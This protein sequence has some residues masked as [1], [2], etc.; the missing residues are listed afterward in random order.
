V[1]KL[2]GVAP[3]YRTDSELFEGVGKLDS[4]YKG[5]GTLLDRLKV[6]YKR[7]ELPKDKII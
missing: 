7:K 3:I 1:K 4:L 6:V 2:Y 5:S